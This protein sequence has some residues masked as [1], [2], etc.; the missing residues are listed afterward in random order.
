MSDLQFHQFPCLND[1]YGVLVHDP[2]G[3]ETFSVDAPEADAVLK[4]LRDTGWKLTHILVTHHHDDHI[5]GIARVKAETGAMVIGPASPSI[6]DLDRTVAEGD[7]IDLVGEEIQVIATPG[8]T[9]D[10]L[11]YYLPKSSAVFAGDT[12][13]AMG[14]GRVFEGTPAMMWDSLKKLMALPPETKVYCGHEYTLANAKFS[15][16]VDGTNPDLIARLAEVEALRAAGKPTLPTTMGLEL[17]TNPFLRA[18][19]ATIRTNLGM[20]SASDA[21]VFTEI[22]GRKDRG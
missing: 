11:N 3:G 10:M 17:K 18:A 16:T 12:L 8:H 9:L 15:M 1:N 6:A 20:Q 4:A 21:Q 13:F 7:T 14:C 19:D 5:Q 2:V 22:R